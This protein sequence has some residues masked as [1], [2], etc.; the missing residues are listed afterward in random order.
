[1]LAV[2]SWYLG[3]AILGGVIGALVM[4][5]YLICKGV[6]KMLFKGVKRLSP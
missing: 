6:L 5:A 4:I 2:L 3:G 1:M